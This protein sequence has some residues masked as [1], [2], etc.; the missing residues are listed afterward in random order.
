MAQEL[1]AKCSRV[2]HIICYRRGVVWSWCN[3]CVSGIVTPL[4][5]QQTA[6]AS[7][8][9]PIKKCFV[10]IR[11]GTGQI[12]AI[13][14]PPTGPVQLMTKHPISILKFMQNPIHLPMPLYRV[15]PAHF[16]WS[17]Q[18]ALFNNKHFL[19]L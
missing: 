1:E 10:E 9:A 8:F 16:K 7:S 12:L 14:F 18:V 19:L 11:N 2:D 4:P 3:V 6:K 5:K 17:G 13:V 15:S